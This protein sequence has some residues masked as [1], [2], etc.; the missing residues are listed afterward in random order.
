MH[1]KRFGDLAMIIVIVIS[2]IN[3]F[4]NCYFN[5]YLMINERCLLD[6][7]A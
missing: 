7:Y 6:I 3:N 5:K 2:D 4:W 1:R